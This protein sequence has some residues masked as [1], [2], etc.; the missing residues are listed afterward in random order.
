MAVQLLQ[1]KNEI[2]FVRALKD[3]KTKPA[4]MIP[5]LTSG[6]VNQSRSTTNTETKS[7]TVHSV[8]SLTTTMSANFEDAIAEVADE[9]REAI[10]KAEKIEVWEVRL[11]RVKDGKYWARYAQGYVTQ[12]N[13]TNAPN[14]VATRAVTFT[15]EGE[16]K[17]GWTTMPDGAQEEIDYVFKGLGVLSSDDDKGG[18]IE[19]NEAS[20]KGAGTNDAPDESAKPAAQPKPTDGQ[21]QG[22]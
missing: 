1:G 11:D 17:E 15:V 22:K 3:A 4:T 10:T 20:D 5:Y 21:G 16:P 7:G 8:G 6:T 14:A 18:G 13:S 9:I 12:D 2:F 19:W